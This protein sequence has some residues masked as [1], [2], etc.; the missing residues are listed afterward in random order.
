MKLGYCAQ[1]RNMHFLDTFGGCNFFYFFIFFFNDDI[2]C[3]ILIT[4]QLYFSFLEVTDIANRAYSSSIVP[5]AR[6][7]GYGIFAHSRVKSLAC[8]F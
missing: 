3:K 5:P 4:L 6:D 1:V 8:K 7:K 2:S